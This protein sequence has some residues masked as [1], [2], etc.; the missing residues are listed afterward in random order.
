M[1]AGT[2]F[3]VAS[4]ISAGV[5]IQLTNSA[6]QPILITCTVANLPSAVAGYAAG[7]LALT[8][9]A[10]VIY[11]NSSTTSSSFSTTLSS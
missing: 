2:T 10:G 3:S 6:G 1:S 5:S 4:P 9:D 11:K 7:C 8:S